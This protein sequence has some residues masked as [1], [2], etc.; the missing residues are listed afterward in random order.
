M[1]KEQKVGIAVIGIIVLII[2]GI[3][4]GGG[5]STPASGVSPIASA[6][7]L[8][9]AVA[10]PA[11]AATS[12]SPAA[13]AAKAKAKPRRTTIRPATPA[14]AKSK[15]AAPPPPPTTAP[16]AAPST[17]TDCYPLT[18]GGTAIS[19]ANTAATATTECPEWPVTANA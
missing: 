6:S 16:A 4:N 9:S 5:K 11:A 8:A 10:S 1:K 14:P 12:A 2:I 17:P 3:V 19:P 18:N 13:A 7:A 15:K